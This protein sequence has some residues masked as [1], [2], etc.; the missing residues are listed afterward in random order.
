MGWILLPRKLV[1]QRLA[2]LRMQVIHRVTGI[3]QVIDF[4]IFGIQALIISKSLILLAAALSIIKTLKYRLH[5]LD[6]VF[7]V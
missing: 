5:R 1:M 6:R 4:K 7:L 3:V 2:D